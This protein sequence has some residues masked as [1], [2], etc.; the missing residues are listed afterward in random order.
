M[1][2]AQAENAIPLSI[3]SGDLACQ[4]G[5]TLLARF[6]SGRS[7]LV[8]IAHP[9]RLIDLFKYASCTLGGWSGTGLLSTLLPGR[10]ARSV[11]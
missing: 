9:D 11:R 3:S 4:P 8:P 5:A 7:R 1:P 10:I 6:I 2:P